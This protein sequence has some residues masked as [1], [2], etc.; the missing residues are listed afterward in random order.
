VASSSLNGI[1]GPAAVA[2][3]SHNHL[4]VADYRNNRILEISSGV[5]TTVA[6]SLH[7]SPLALPDGV[8]VD[9]N[10]NIYIGRRTAQHDPRSRRKR[11]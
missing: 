8:A 2:V 9:S 10:G 3:D 6:G 11:A 4:Y 1:N 5:T 7:S